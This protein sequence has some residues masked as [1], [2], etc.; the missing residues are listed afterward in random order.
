MKRILSLIICATLCGS[1]ADND[2]LTGGRHDEGDTSSSSLEIF[3]VT[4][5]EAMGV[6]TRVAE[7]L[8]TGESIGVYLQGTKTAGETECTPVNNRKY[9]LLE[10]GWGPALPTDTIYLYQEKAQVSAYYPYDENMKYTAISYN[11]ETGSETGRTDY[12]NLIPLST[13]PYNQSKELFID[14]HQE[15]D[16]WNR[17]V[18][19]NL[20]HAYSRLKLSIVRGDNY[21]L[22]VCKLSS[23]S[24][25][26]DSLFSNGV[27]DLTDGK[28]KTRPD[29][30]YRREVGQYAVPAACGGGSSLPYEFNNVNTEYAIDLLVVPTQLKED[31]S[32]SVKGMG[33]AI[34]VNVGGLPATVMVPLTDLPKFESGKAYTISMVLNGVQLSP[35]TVTTIGWDEKT[36]N[37]GED[38][39]PVPQPKK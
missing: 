33:L 28:V 6:S 30:T 31:A 38:Y 14:L 8:T 18:T 36:L 32:S 23:V 34:V 22:S 26:N 9:T 19:F 25:A 16:L 21:P 3:S 39:E 35:P 5:D 12:P 2:E 29:D 4:V 15:V 17:D 27:L 11:E 20:K 13:Q 7:P 37:G 24:L 10:K 1:C